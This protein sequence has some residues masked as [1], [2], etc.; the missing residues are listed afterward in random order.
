[1]QNNECECLYGIHDWE[2][3]LHSKKQFLNKRLCIVHIPKDKFH[4]DKY[5]LYYV[6]K[7]NPFEEGVKAYINFCPYCG[8]KLV[9]NAE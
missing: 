5:C 4:K 8:R 6:C 3:F 1:M 2:L 7:E 9:I